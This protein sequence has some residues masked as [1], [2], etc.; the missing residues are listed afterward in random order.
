MHNH[1]GHALAQCRAN[2]ARRGSGSKSE[3]EA[4]G[5]TR[6]AA[7]EPCLALLP[8]PSPTQPPTIDRELQLPDENYAALR[9]SHSLDELY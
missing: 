4:S 2:S 8:S 5:F 1:S 6:R 3:V 7:F 9:R